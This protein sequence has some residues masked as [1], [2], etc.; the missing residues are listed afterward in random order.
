MT[1][2]DYITPINSPIS[3]LPPILYRVNKN[4][5]MNDSIENDIDNNVSPRITRRRLDFIDIS[6]LNNSLHI[7]DDDMISISPIS[8]PAD[9]LD[10]IGECG[11]CYEKLPLK[12][13]HIFTTCGHLFCVKCLL[14][15]NNTSSTCPLCRENL[16][17]KIISNNINLNDNVSDDIMFEERHNRLDRYVYDDIDIEWTETVQEDDDVIFISNRE[18]TQLRE[19]RHFVITLM[20]RRMYLNSLLSNIHFDGQIYHSFIPRINYTN[21]SENEM[22]KTFLYEFVICRD[23]FHDGDEIN[24]FGYIHDIQVV[25]VLFSPFQQNQNWDSNHEYCFKVS[26]F[27]PNIINST[28][29]DENGLFQ[30]TPMI[31]RFSEIRRLYSIWSITGIYD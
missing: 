16:Y 7:S 31:F 10:S 21:L 5:S 3:N 20:Q 23:I 27:N 14:N 8:L 11:V 9:E 29:D 18:I 25:E 1:S 26:A 2:I 6:P 28:Y 24:Y 22:D 15:W 4:R 12:S 17:D 19:V 30:T 13:N